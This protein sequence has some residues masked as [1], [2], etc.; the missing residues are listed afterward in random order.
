[1]NIDALARESKDGSYVVIGKVAEFY[2][3]NYADPQDL[4]AIPKDVF[5]TLD[6]AVAFAADFLKDHPNAGFDVG[7]CVTE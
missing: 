2:S 7:K 1:M 5:P 3:V 4:M 6:E